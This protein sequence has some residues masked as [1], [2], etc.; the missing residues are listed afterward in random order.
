[1][2]VSRRRKKKSAGGTKSRQAEGYG[3]VL[4][5]IALV[6]VL[7]AVT[8]LLTGGAGKDGTAD[9]TLPALSARAAEGH[10]TF[11]RVC[12]ACH[13]ENAQG[14]SKGP[15]LIQVT[16]RPNHHGDQA[17]RLAVATGARQHHWSFGNMPP[18]PQVKA[19]EIGPIIAFI[20]ETQRAN[21][22]Q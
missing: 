8:W 4:T 22:I 7:G 17:I 2:P 19:G 14:S 18:Q 3:G 5:L 6:A 15:S 21:G 10:K 1:M 20:R 12:A 9:V 13:G 16:Y 11:K